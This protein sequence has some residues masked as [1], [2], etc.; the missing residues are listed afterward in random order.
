MLIISFFGRGV[1]ILSLVFVNGQSRDSLQ[2][3]GLELFQQLLRDNMSN[4]AAC[5]RAGMLS[6]LLDWFSQENN[7]SVITQIAQLIQVIGGHSISGKDIRKIFALL[8]SERVVN[9]QQYCSLLL[10]SVLYMLNEK[11]PTA[12]FDM[13]GID[14]V[15]TFVTFGNL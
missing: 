3:H 9:Q 14:S 13:N 4:R 15:S 6:L 10:S 1:S 5:V 8:R 7:D 2:Q 11:G 12:F